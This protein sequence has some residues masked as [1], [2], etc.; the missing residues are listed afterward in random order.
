ME[1]LNDMQMAPHDWRNLWE[2]GWKQ[3][4]GEAIGLPLSAKSG[5]SGPYQNHDRFRTISRHT[6]PLRAFGTANFKPRHDPRLPDARPGF[7]NGLL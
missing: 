1:Q 7:Y 2:R 4:P 5:G 6:R 3:F